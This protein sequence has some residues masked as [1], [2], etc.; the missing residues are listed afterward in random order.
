[1]EERGA[2]TG[3]EFILDNRKL[4][5][6]F[7]LLIIIC[8]IFFVIGFM[9]GKRQAVHA[10][11]PEQSPEPPVAQAAES[12]GVPTSKSA[13]T[14]ERSLKEGLEWYKTVQ[15][16]PPGATKGVES[17]RSP[18]AAKDQPEPAPVPKGGKPASTQPVT[19]NVLSVGTSYSVQVGAFKRLR[20]AEIVVD[21]LRSKGYTA[22][23]ED[24]TQSVQLYLVKVGRFASRADAVAMQ[25]KLKKDGFNCF[26]KTN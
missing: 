13:E 17:P 18:A 6:G 15:G 5:V 14:G 20:E 4:I 10:R 11:M 21:S 22:T 7:M 8:G 12:G 23:I 1:M 2:E 19:S 24:P 26:I 9:E 25:L 16:A 3:T